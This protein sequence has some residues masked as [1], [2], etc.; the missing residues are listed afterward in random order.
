MN[1]LTKDQ[2]AQ[3]LRCLVEGNS[4]RS[5]GRIC[6]VSKNT[7][8]KLLP[9]AGQACLDYQDKMLVNLPCKRVQ[10]DEIWAFCYCKEKNIPDRLIGQ[11]GVGSI[12]TWTAM[13]ADTKLVF[14]WHVGARDAV[15]AQYLMSDAASRL[16][17]KVQLTTDGNIVYLTAVADNFAK[18]DFAQLVK[19]YG[20]EQN[21]EKTYSPAKCLGAKRKKVMGEPDPAHISTSFAER[22]NLNIRM[23][24]RRWTRL[25]NAF[26][27]KVENM[28]YQIAIN[29]FYHNFI[30]RHQTLRMPPALKAGIINYPMSIM[31]IVEM[32][33]LP[34]A[35]KRGPY[36]KRAGDSEKEIHNDPLH[37]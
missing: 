17:N 32:L 8:L 1:T 33:P 2:Q 23:E 25:T 4:I 37:K 6:G 26:S 31:D 10:C 18:I 15:A 5:T 21:P 14:S 36:K 9:L 20:Q 16:A 27:K 28:A 24:S 11:P 30:R 34:V 13:C 22:Q 29:F 19:L 12:W 3:I 7:I 35:K